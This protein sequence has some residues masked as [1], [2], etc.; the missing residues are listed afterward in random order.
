MTQENALRIL[1]SGANVFLTGEPGSGKTHTVNQFVSEAR[2]RG[3][4]VAM[5]ASTGIAATHLNGVTIHSWCGIGIK[6]KLSKSDLDKI[7]RNSRVRERVINADILVIDEISMLSATTLW[8]VDMVCKTVRGDVASFGGLQIVVVGDFFQLPPIVKQSHS[9]Q[10]LFANENISPFAFTSAV[11]RE[12]NFVIC[13]LTEQYRTDDR[14]FAA[15]LSAIRNQTFSDAHLKQLAS[16]RTSLSVKQTDVIKL[17]AHNADVDLINRQKLAALKQ[18][19]RSYTMAT[20]GPARLTDALI[21]NCLSP[22]I[23]ELKVGA[24]VM[25]TKNNAK[26]GFV[27]GTLGVVHDF[28]MGTGWPIIKT[29]SGKNLTIEPMDWTAEDV[30]GELAKI[31][32]VPLRLA[33]AITVH[34]SQGMSLDEAVID[35][36]A[37]FEYGQGYVALSRLRRLSGLHLLGWNERALAVHPEVVS[38]DTEFRIAAQKNEDN[39]DFS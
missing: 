39:I 20:F 7:K 14:Q 27:N 23:L 11:W 38:I 24:N 12:A 33:W 34:K 31:V 16:R 37:V 15:L 13:Y 8:L 30:G 6:D 3:K 22:Q 32:Q 21:K 2:Q 18:P 25:C 29:K 35:L 28:E 10:A 5:T 26:V 19:G 17:F 4:K 9:P 36:R 1:R